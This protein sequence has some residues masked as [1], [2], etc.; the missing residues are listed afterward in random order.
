MLTPG[1]AFVNV[2]VAVGPPAS[3]DTHIVSHAQG[4][5]GLGEPGR[6]VRRTYP[7]GGGRPVDVPRMLARVAAWSI[8]RLIAC[9]V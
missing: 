5:G 2:T 8:R 6:P 7:R 9:D 4:R 1:E 3:V